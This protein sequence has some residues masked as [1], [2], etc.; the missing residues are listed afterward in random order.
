M[1]AMVAATMESTIKSLRPPIFHCKN[2]LKL[3]IST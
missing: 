3:F 2:W 1:K